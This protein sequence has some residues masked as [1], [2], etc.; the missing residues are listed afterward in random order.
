MRTNDR[1][2]C[3]GFFHLYYKED[4]PISLFTQEEN[5]LQFLQLF[6]TYVSPIAEVYSYCLLPNQLHFLLK[7]KP[8]KMVFTYFKIEGRFP[9]ETITLEDIQAL[10][11][12][13]EFQQQNILSI[14]LQK[15]FTNFFQA[16]TRELKQE[17]GRKDNQIVHYEQALLT[18]SDEI[19]TCILHIHAVAVEKGF[20]AEFGAWRYNSY[21]AM[22]S[23]KPTKLMR[24]EVIDIFGSKDNF[25]KQ[26]QLEIKRTA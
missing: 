11:A 6:F 15:Q 8:E 3:D 1:L 22:L 25:I 13:P 26:H 21:N 16:Y 10:S 12:R 24:K 7:I 5:Y 17:L 19:K 2:I 14:H 9:D 20:G 23:D 4:R 18:E